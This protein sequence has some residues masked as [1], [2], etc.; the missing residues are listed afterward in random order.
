MELPTFRYHPDPIGSGSVVASDTTCACC[1]KSRGHIYTGPVYAEEDLE[2][3][4]CPWCIADGAAHKKFDATFVDSE[5]FPDDAPQDAVEEIVERTPGYN[6]WQSEVWPVCCDDAAAFLTPAGIKELRSQQDLEGIAMTYIVQEMGISGG[7]AT[8][9]LTSLNKDAGPTAYL[10][11]C[12][13]CG[14]HLL[15]IDQA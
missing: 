5:A 4:L 8:R 7:A 11:Q 2:D 12:L 10:F 3:A 15:H 9:L 6:A 13:H 1:G 14:R